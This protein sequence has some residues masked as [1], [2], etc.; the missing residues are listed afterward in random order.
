MNTDKQTKEKVFTIFTVTHFRQKTGW[1]RAQT[2][3]GEILLGTSIIPPYGTIRVQAHFK[4]DPTFG[5]QWE[6]QDIVYKD[7]KAIT[8][9]LLK[10]NFIAGISDFKADSV[11]DTFGVDIWGILDAGANG[12]EYELP[13]G[14]HVNP[15]TLLQDANGVGPIVSQDMI[16]SW[17]ENREYFSIAMNSVRCH[18]KTW[19]W[20]RI[21]K[22]G[23]KSKIFDMMCHSEAPY[24][25]YDLVQFGLKFQECDRLAFEDWD[26]KPAL[27]PEH[28][29]R[30]AGVVKFLVADHTTR[31]DSPFNG[32]SCLPYAEIE[33]LAATE[34]GIS[35]IFEKLPSDFGAL[36]LTMFNNY[37][38]PSSYFETELYL[39]KFLVR[40]MKLSRVRTYGHVTP[41]YLQGISPEGIDLSDEQIAALQRAIQS[42][43]SIILGGPGVGKTTILRV[44]TDFFETHGEQ[45]HLGAFTGAASRRMQLATNH[46]AS[47]L[48]RMLGLGS[49]TP[50]LITSGTIIID[51]MS[52]NSSRLM[53]EVFT[54]V[55][56][57][58]RVIMVG[59]PDQLPPID[60]GEPFI[61]FAETNT[62]PVMR[63]T[64]IYRQKHGSSIAEACR[65][66]NAGEVPV[67]DNEET[68]I[69]TANKA[70]DA[71]NRFMKAWRYFKETQPELGRQALTPLNTRPII[72]RTALNA[73]VQA[74]D[75][76][77]GA[78]IPET[79]IRVGDRI[80]QLV[81]DYEKEVRNGMTGYAYSRTIDAENLLVDLGNATRKSEKNALLDLNSR[82]DMLVCKFDED[83]RYV[84]YTLDDLG[85]K[86][87]DIAYAM[88][89]HKSQGNQFDVVVVVLPTL[90]ENMQL[91]QIVYTAMSRAK[92]FL[93]VISEGNTFEKCIKNDR[94]LRRLSQLSNL[95]LEAW[96]SETVDMLGWK[97]S[98]SEPTVDEDI[99][100]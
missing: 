61:Q 57:N 66:V 34:Y 64:K 47:T 95:F 50:T 25:V 72:G 5:P 60:W 14:R 94:K 65:L 98:N 87:V 71:A 81:N 97:E 9:T 39:A 62:I 92:K 84:N 99:P 83:I 70:G 43:V 27:T 30:L 35:D 40:Q 18:L 16:D 29:I 37:V 82:N 74:E 91:R 88:T 6:I 85:D 1:F 67:G 33:Q 28:P 11:F 10:S 24:S 54:K 45:V 55:A 44:L 36:G 13:D 49:E 23:T 31:W 2:V 89:V 75:N 46:E 7:M 63:L 19:Q 4:I 78:P 26:D 41:E 73:V 42:P 100:W 68:F 80:V 48:H 3:D 69:L 59:D 8:L 17:R 53:W 56:P 15:K 38:Y 52:M 77:L 86:D 79:P 32:S 22:D 21:A 51:E 93:V 20:R 96:E 90:P 58:V 12:E 76:P